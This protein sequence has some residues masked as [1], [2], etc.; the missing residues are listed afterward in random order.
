MTRNKSAHIWGMV[1]QAEIRARTES[2]HIFPCGR[3][4]VMGESHPGEIWAVTVPRLGKVSKASIF[5]FPFCFNLI[6]LSI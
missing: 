1:F 3:R 5:E 2:G 6:S 4:G